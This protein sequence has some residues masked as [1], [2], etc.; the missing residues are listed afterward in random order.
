[1]DSLELLEP[2]EQQNVRESPLVSAR[3]I[4]ESKDSGKS[5]SYEQQEYRDRQ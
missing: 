4:T 1:M 3:T 2:A 5:D